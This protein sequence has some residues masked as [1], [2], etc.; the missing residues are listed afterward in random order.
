MNLIDLNLQ[1]ESLKISLTIPIFSSLSFLNSDEI[2]GLDE[3][4]QMLY[5]FNFKT[6]HI[7]SKGFNQKSNWMLYPF[8][9][10]IYQKINKNCI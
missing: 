1:Y 4:S 9:F 2:L 7:E 10:S 8:N 6:E 5:K 3:S